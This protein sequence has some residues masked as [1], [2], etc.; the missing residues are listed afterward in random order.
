M[1]V[2]KYN[3]HILVLPEDDANRQIANGF[4][5]DPA[6][7]DRAIQI[8]P[9]PGGWTKV[10]NAFRD[11]HISEMHK[12]KNRMMLLLVDFD[13]DEKRL[14]NIKNK[15]PDDLKE[16]VFVLGAQSEPENIKKNIANL[17]TFEDI[18]KALAQDCVNETEN[19]WGHELLKHNRNELKRMISSVK[20][21][22][23]N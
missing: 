1:S 20:P 18:G 5:L 16:R 19:I 22:L 7:N 13:H 2:N 17:N 15:I 10:L 21:F 4:L 8:L 23:F 12:Y 11:N 9:P 6:L 3:K 14:G